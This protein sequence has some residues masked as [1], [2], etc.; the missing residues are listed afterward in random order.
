MSSFRPARG[1]SN[2]H[3]QS[4]LSSMGP[5]KILEPQRAKKLTKHAE[6]VVIETPEGV[7]LLAYLTKQCSVSSLKANG[8]AIILHG[9]E[10]S[11]DSLYVLSTGRK[12]LAAG[13]DVLRLNLRDHGDS[14]HLNDEVFNSTRLQEVIDAVKLACEAWGGQHNVLCGYSLGGNFSIRV[15]RFAQEADINLHQVV[16]ICPVLHPPTTMEA[17]NNGV[18]LYEQYFVRKWK[19]SLNTK[20]SH[21]P[22]LDFG[23]ALPKLKTLD[24]MNDFFVLGYTDFEQTNDYFEAYAIV[25]DFLAELSTPTTI[26]TSAD[27]PMIPPAQLKEL[28]PSDYLTVELEEFGGHCAFI[29]DWSFDSW[30]SDRIVEIAQCSSSQQSL[31]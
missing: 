13:Y 17:L 19:K 3:L 22:N 1:L 26:I 8:L 4:I 15:A 7:K 5:R 28:A 23:P 11:S 16:A 21:F 20:L 2:P 12:L 14:H 18:S 10:G 24:E 9:W 27:D 31:T 30:A 6:E 29:K 25:G